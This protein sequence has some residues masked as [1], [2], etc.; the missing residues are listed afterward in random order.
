[1]NKHS[2]ESVLGSILGFISIVAE[3]T[4]KAIT[5]PRDRP[6]PLLSELTEKQ[7]NNKNVKKL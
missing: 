4:D 7:D 1:M 2:W 3:P 5:S 6:Y